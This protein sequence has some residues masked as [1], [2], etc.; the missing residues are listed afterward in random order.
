MLDK[1]IRVLNFDNS[2]IQQC[3][4]L[5]QYTTK[6]IDFTSLASFARLYISGDFG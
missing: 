2:I 6:V 4:L 3:R 5:S 1:G